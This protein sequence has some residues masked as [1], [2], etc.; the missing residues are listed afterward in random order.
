MRDRLQFPLHSL[1]QAA[2]AAEHGISSECGAVGLARGRED[3]RVRVVLL[4]LRP[5]DAASVVEM[6][7]PK[8]DGIEYD[9]DEEQ[10]P[11][12]A[13][14]DSGPRGD[15]WAKVRGAVLAF[16]SEICGRRLRGVDLALAG[17]GV[18]GDERRR[19]AA[20]AEACVLLLADR[21]HLP[22]AESATLR[23][24]LRAPEPATS[25]LLW[26]NRWASGAASRSGKSGRSG[27]VSKS[28]GSYAD[29]LNSDEDDDDGA[30]NGGGAVAAFV[31]FGT[32]VRAVGRSV[33]VTVGCAAGLAAE[34]PLW[35]VHL[36]GD[37]PWHVHALRPAHVVVLQEGERALVQAE[38]LDAD[39][40][41]VPSAERLMHATLLATPA[42]PTALSEGIASQVDSATDLPRSFNL[43]KRELG[44]FMQGV[45]EFAKEQ[46]Q[47][48]AEKARAK[49][50]A[51]AEA[52]MATGDA[53]DVSD[54]LA[55]GTR[56]AAY[57]AALGEIDDFEE[58]PLQAWL[59]GE[60]SDDE[61]YDDG[62]EAAA[63]GLGDVDNDDDD[64]DGEDDD[65]DP[66]DL[67]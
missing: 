44:S 66:G 10:E 32:I 65:F 50:V 48:A 9:S 38:L 24:T 6:E 42:V 58:E 18:L 30:A 28:N 57:A 22:A 33:R 21:N 64:D 4:P 25:Q 23:A 61:S 51:E 16:D 36:K 26:P 31:P 13:G 15:A 43:Q 27:R 54:V 19:V 7:L 29:A 63:G 53:V 35:G 17:F 67:S 5:D 37:Q 59:E 2:V 41:G 46:Q 40:R 62:E 52:E 60:S 8:K 11:P 39:G 47:K 20:F 55:P 1:L 3:R 12:E 14:P 34:L 56:R 45:N 49:A